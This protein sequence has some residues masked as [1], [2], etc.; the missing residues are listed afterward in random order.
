MLSETL[1]PIGELARRTG[2]NPVTLRAWERRYG[3]LKPQRT[4]KG[5]RLYG[6]DQLERVQA[7]LGWLERGASVGQ[8]RELLD[9]PVKRAPMGDWQPRQLQLIEA[10]AHLS[11]RSLDQQ[12]NQV[13]ALYPAVTL[14]EQLL[15]P[16]L[17]SLAVRWRSH[18]NARLEQ[19]F[20]HTWLRSKLGAR[21]Y[22]DNQS[23]QGPAVLLC[24]DSERPFDP[25]LWL[26]AWLLSSNGIPVEVLEQPVG[27]AQLQRAV[28]TLQPWAVLMHLGPRIDAS[29]LQRTLQGIG[30]TKL[31]GG[32]TLALHQAELH[33]FDLPDLFLFD[34]PQAALRVL[35]GNV[36]QPVETSAPC[37]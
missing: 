6:Q 32:A 16:L 2:V 30:V 11:Q 12:L 23:L 36:R 7:I 27:G 34:T 28:T 31:L 22:H 24:E 10:I 19:V 21:V 37:N 13:M 4:A 20:F 25:S 29:T 5:H 33:A 1:V 14:C 17:A 35:Q 8:V 26:C 3:L 9:Q 15:L 18:F